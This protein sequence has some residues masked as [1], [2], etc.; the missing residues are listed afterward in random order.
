MEVTKSNRCDLSEGTILITDYGIYEITAAY[1][2]SSQ[3]YYAKDLFTKELEIL[4]KSDII[5]GVVVEIIQGDA[6]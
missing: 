3:S 6:E 2:E 5:N 4:H 1:D